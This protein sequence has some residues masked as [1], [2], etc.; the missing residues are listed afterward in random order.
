MV[1]HVRALG[2]V[3]RVEL[4]L[5]EGGQTIEAHIPRDWIEALALAKGW[6]VYISPTNVRVFARPEVS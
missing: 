2:P 4:D 5:V 1:R 3:V 6:R